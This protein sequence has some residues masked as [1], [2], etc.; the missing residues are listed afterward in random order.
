VRVPKKCGLSA[1]VGNKEEVFS[2]S[3][4]IDTNSEKVFVGSFYDDIKTFF[5]F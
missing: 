5:T 4:G 1:G 2:F 3:A